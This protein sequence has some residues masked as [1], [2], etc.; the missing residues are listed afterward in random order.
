VYNVQLRFGKN[1]DKHAGYSSGNKFV[2]V[3]FE[4]ET[5]CGAPQ[6]VDNWKVKCYVPSI[7]CP[8]AV[9]KGGGLR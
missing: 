8:T 7:S 9:K 2:D 6:E 3:Y 4:C 1:N 5:A